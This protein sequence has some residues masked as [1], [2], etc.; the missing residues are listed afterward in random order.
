M[1]YGIILIIPSDSVCLILMSIDFSLVLHISL[2]DSVE[3]QVINTTPDQ[4]TSATSSQSISWKRRGLMSHFCH[5]QSI[6]FLNKI[7][8]NLN[9]YP[10]N[11]DILLLYLYVL[12]TARNIII[13][14][15]KLNLALIF[16]IYKNT[17][18]QHHIPCNMFPLN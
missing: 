9:Q 6:F 11:C 12:A 3:W 13:L 17:S 18:I 4:T 15:F 1:C 8:L 16:I 2:I 14:N 5:A 7:C 10:G